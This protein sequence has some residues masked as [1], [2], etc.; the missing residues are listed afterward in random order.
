MAGQ[1]AG[2]A[3][4]QQLPVSLLHDQPAAS[5]QQ[6]AGLPQ[7]LAALL[8]ALQNTGGLAALAP[9]LQSS[10]AGATL[11]ALAGA[12]R[13][14]GGNNLG[15]LLQQL[16]PQQQQQA[17]AP[18]PPQ[19]QLPPALAGALANLPPSLQQ[20][21]LSAGGA[22]GGGAAALPQHQH[23]QRPALNSLQHLMPQL[24]GNARC[25][26]ASPSCAP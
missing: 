4:P 19:P 21:L 25:R 7:Q 16:L 5:A 20:M 12:G 15:A 13:G 14:L 1:P 10:G 17:P 18:L 11:A 22:A 23:Q 6:Q 9:L 2:G 8:P 24:A 3:L 26:N